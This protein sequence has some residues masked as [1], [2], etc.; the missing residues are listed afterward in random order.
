MKLL[1]P[2]LLVGC[3]AP[4]VVPRPVSHDEVETNVKAIFE[5]T[6]SLL[7][8][9]GEVYCAGVFYKDHIITAAHCVDDKV[10]VNVGF[11]RH[12][13]EDGAYWLHKYIYTVKAIHEGTDAAIL[14]P[15][16]MTAGMHLNLTLAKGPYVGQRVYLVGH[17][18]G[19]PY[20]LSE[21]RLGA[22]ARTM[23]GYE[24]MLFSLVSAPAYPGNSGGPCLNDDGEILG[25]TSFTWYGKPN[26]TGVVHIDS[27]RA[28]LKEA[29]V[30]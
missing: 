17:P 10:A 26:L 7:T 22:K 23:P 3:L 25:V 21:G 4:Q 6:A 13:Q 11:H 16:D 19:M 14:E 15:A 30:E 8:N 1:F 12:F 9:A 20:S 28:L 24:E 2:L 5:S 27:I 18:M 29:G